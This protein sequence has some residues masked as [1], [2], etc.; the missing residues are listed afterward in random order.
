[1]ADEYNEDYYNLL[2]QQN[3]EALLNKEVQLDNAR[4]RAMKSTN[5]NLMGLGLASSG[6][7]QTANMGV[8]NQYLSAL[9]NA[10]Q[11]FQTEQNRLE[12]E[13][14]QY[15]EGMRNSEYEKFSGMLGAEEIDNLDSLNNLMNTYSLYDDMGNLNYQK[16]VELFGES[17]ARA[18]KIAYD[19][20]KRLIEEGA[21]EGAGSLGIEANDMQTAA[22]TFVDQDGRT[23]TVNDELNLL[24]GGRGSAAFQKNIGYQPQD[25]DV[26]K[27][28]QNSENNAK[29]TYIM[30]K[31]GKWYQATYADYSKAKN[32]HWLRS[33]KDTKYRYYWDNT[34]FS[35]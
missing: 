4:R 13:H 19:E 27:V 22:S 23:G 25:G 30:Y 5:A 21:T 8:E 1:M 16:A 24:F 7:G 28:S 12:T 29:I 17:N 35:I 3:Y 32:K 18:L 11:G 10:N 9:E 34:K 2:K 31:N 26:I 15:L 6:Y 33:A 14:Q 20:K